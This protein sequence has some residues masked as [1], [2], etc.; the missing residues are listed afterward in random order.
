[1]NADTS[2]DTAPPAEIAYLLK[3]YPRTSETFIANEIYLL[4]QQ[5]LR[6]R[7]FSMLTLTDPQRHAVVDATRAPLRYL[8]QFTS[9]RATPFPAWLRDNLP[10]YR[11]SHDRLFSARPYAYVATLLLALRLAF[12]HNKGSWRQP[13]TAFI[14]EFLQA[15]FIAD[16]ILTSEN[17]RHLHAH[18]CHA[19]TTVTMFAS[20]LSGLPFSFTA[21]AKDIYVETQNPGDL[22]SQKLRRAQFAVTCTQANHT[23]L[24][25]LG[26]TQTPVHTIYHGLDTTQFIPRPEPATPE[27]PL[28]LTVGRMVEKKG[29]PVLLHALRLLRERGQPFHCLFISGGGALAPEIR[30]LIQT[31]NLG[32]VVTVQSAVTQE[33]LQR[34][35]HQATLFVLPCQ[36]AANRDRDGIPNVLVEAMATGLPV[37]STDVSGIPEL[38]E[39][40]VSGWLVP[41][42]NPGALADAIATLLAS[43]EQRRALGR[44]A[45]EKVCRDF[46]ATQHIQSLQKLFLDC[47]G[48]TS[49]ID[50]G[51]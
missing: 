36:I 37:I 9:L 25:S 27:T 24:T 43:P 1:M 31:L 50:A 21:H 20:R 10:A 35:Y 15:G 26:V 22:L 13:E 39:H 4:E 30:A 5:G 46:D 19:A 3:S 34:I 41:Q 44:A 38:I 16:E 18:F 40:G 6:L 23:Y 28:L 42:K 47:L 8:P 12:R 32:E 2:R 48:E 29:F 17:V 14:R 33:T 49:P 51:S 11:D 45:R 7:L